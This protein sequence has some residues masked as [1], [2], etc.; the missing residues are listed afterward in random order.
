[1]QQT[2]KRIA[3]FLDGTWNTV[4]DNTNVWRLHALCAKKSRDGAEQVFYY[5]QGVGTRFGEQFRGGMFGYGLDRNIKAAY[6]WLIENYAPRDEIY[7]FGFS[8]GAFTA[9]SLVGLIAR[10]GLLQPG[11]PLSLEEVFERYRRGLV[12]RPLYQLEY[13]RRELLRREKYSVDTMDP[14]IHPLTRQETSLLAYCTRVPIKMIGVFDTVGAL[15]VPF[16]KSHWFH[17]THLS[18]IYKHSYQALGIDEHR[19]AFAPTLWTR[20]T[21]N[22]PDSTARQSKRRENIAEQRWFIGAHAN[23]GGGYPDN[24]LSQLSLAWMVEKAESHGLAFRYPVIVDAESHRDPIVDSY[25]Q[26]LHGLYAKVTRRHQRMIGAPRR[27]VAKGFSDNVNETIDNSVF[28]RWRNDSK[29]RPFGLAD[30]SARRGIDPA[31]ITGSV[32]A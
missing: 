15:G 5:D 17:N 10:C 13:E 25:S 30:W 12:Q 24:R 7:V 18:T 27:T 31:E 28:D 6:R 20:F 4:A 11:A 26:F 8:R 19:P 23:V 16:G 22:P 21:P 2:G 14:P 9:R 3:M 29:Y 1:M 32:A